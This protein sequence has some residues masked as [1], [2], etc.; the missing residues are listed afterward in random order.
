MITFIARMTVKEHC[1]ADFIALIRQLTEK[2]HQHEPDTTA[3]QFYRLREPHRF[4]VLESFTCEE[5]E[6]SHQNT[7]YFKQLAPAIIDCLDGSYVREYL[8]PIE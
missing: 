5:A 7:P 1:E 2:V 6:S 4:A 8:D 3:Y